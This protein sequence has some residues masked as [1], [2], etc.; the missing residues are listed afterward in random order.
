MSNFKTLKTEI[1]RL[2]QADTWTQA[3]KEWI[4]VGVHISEEPETCLCGHTPIKEMC[5]LLNKVTWNTAYV[6]N[7]CVTKFIRIP[8]NRIFSCVRKITKDPS[9]GLNNDLAQY[10]YQR[11]WLNE[12]EITF[13]EQ[14]KRKR[15]LSD[16]QRAVRIKINNKI[17]ANIVR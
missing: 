11:D 13:T 16:K 3:I 9:A 7:V 15:S 5:E 1:L 8:T 2:S 10:A 6:G 12:W 14:T 4:L 17:L